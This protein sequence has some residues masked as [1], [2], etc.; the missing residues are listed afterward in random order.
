MIGALASYLH[1]IFFADRIARISSY[2][3]SL[4]VLPVL[5]GGVIGYLSIVLSGARNT[6]SSKEKWKVAGF[7]VLGVLLPIGYVLL[8]MS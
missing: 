4:A 1:M 3:V 6:L 8:C 2:F 5:F 7:G